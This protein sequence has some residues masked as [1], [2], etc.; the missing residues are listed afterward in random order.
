MDHQQEI[1]W[2]NAYLLNKP[3]A[4]WAKR[5]LAEVKK[6]MKAVTPSITVNTKDSPQ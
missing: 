2:L 5:Q 6:E 3:W 1:D 4:S